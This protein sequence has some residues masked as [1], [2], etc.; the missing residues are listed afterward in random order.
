MPAAKKSIDVTCH[1]FGGLISVCS[2]CPAD[3]ATF[4]RHACCRAYWVGLAC[5][6]AGEQQSTSNTVG[7]VRCNCCAHPVAG[8]MTTFR[9]PRLGTRTA[10][11]ADCGHRRWLVSP[12]AA[13]GSASATLPGCP[14][15]HWQLWP[16]RAADG[17]PWS[18]Q[19]S[20][21]YADGAVTCE[22]L[23][24]QTNAIIY[25]CVRLAASKPTTL[26]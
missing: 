5:Q 22:A 23:A 4:A 12:G 24:G 26:T 14:S 18:S 7:F 21:G 3:V 10:C 25:Q 8:G 1:G 13:S 9:M 17:G 2:P 20:L 19:P 11:V 15:E 16:D 6:P